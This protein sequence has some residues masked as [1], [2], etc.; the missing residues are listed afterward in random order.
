[1]VYQVFDFSEG[2]VFGLPS[3]IVFGAP[4]AIATIAPWSGPPMRLSSVTTI[5]P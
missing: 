4:P 3:T 2:Q 5:S 1:M